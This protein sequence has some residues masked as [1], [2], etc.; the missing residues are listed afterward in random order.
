[1]ERGGELWLVR[2]T[3]NLSYGE[4]NETICDVT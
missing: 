1:M 4:E 3:A 2:I